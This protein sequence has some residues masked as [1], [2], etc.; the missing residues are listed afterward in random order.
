MINLLGGCKMHKLIYT[1]L[2][3]DIVGMVLVGTQKA[4][5]AGLILIGVTG[6]LVLVAIISAVRAERL[7]DRSLS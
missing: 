2:A 1:L 5:I 7:L 3:T 6:A 4:L